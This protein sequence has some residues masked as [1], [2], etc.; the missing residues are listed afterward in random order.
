M[1]KLDQHANLTALDQVA[2]R[3]QDA[4][5]L[6]GNEL[7][8]KHHTAT[9]LIDDTTCQLAEVFDLRAVL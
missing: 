1:T 2:M 3:F 7:L 8:T 6:V 5:V 9:C 4:I